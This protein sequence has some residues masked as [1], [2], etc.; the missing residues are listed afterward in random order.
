MRKYPGTIKAFNSEGT[1]FDIDF[2]DGDKEADIK[3]NLIFS[4]NCK[5]C[6]A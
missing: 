3:K 5:S 4:R 6:I 2:D 1:L